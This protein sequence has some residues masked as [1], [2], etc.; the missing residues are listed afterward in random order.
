LPTV[1]AINLHAL[2]IVQA[3]EQGQDSPRYHIWR[4][5]NQS[6][7]FSHLAHVVMKSTVIDETPAQIDTV[8]IK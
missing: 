8:Y 3:P 5:M 2:T 7:A 4:T 1:A 6:M